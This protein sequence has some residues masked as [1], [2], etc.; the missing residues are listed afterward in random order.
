MLLF[1]RSGSPMVRPSPTQLHS[2]LSRS[3]IIK[4]SSNDSK[5]KKN[6]KQLS[7]IYR[8]SGH[9]TANNRSRAATT[10][11]SATIDRRRQTPITRTFLVGALEEAVYRRRSAL[12]SLE[13][14][15]EK[16]TEQVRTADAEMRK[17]NNASSS[18]RDVGSEQAVVVVIPKTRKQTRDPLTS[19]GRVRARRLEISEEMAKLEELRLELITCEVDNSDSGRLDLENPCLSLAFAESRFRAITGS[20]GKPC[21][22]L[23]RPED[24]WKIVTAESSS[25]G[26]FGRPRGFDGPVFYSPLGVPILVGKPRAESDGILRKV[27][28]GSDLWFQVEDYEGSR[29]LLRSSLKRGVKDSKKCLQM[30]A[31]LAALYSVHGI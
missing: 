14:E 27:S 5:K 24:T 21:P 22:I 31:D 4:H 1:M 9:T 12:E 13:L 19:L 23:D 15:R 26:E 25:K 6:I 2:V 16:L 17:K 8:T 3:T 30:A 10:A 7:H 18:Q 29:V 28:Q 11:G 20:I